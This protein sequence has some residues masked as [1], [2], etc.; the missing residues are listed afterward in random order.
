MDTIDWIAV[1]HWTCLGITIQCFEHCFDLLYFCT[2]ITVKS[3]DLFWATPKLSFSF[4][5]AIH[6]WTCLCVFE[7]C[8]PASPNYTSASA[9]RQMTTPAL[10]QKIFRRI[11]HSFFNYGK[12]SRSCGSNAS[13]HYT[14]LPPYLIF[15]WCS[16]HQMLFLLYTKHDR[17]CVIQKV[18]HLS[19]EYYPRRHGD[20]PTNIDASV[21]W[22]WFL[23]C[24]SPMNPVFAQFLIVESW[25]LTTVETRESCTSLNCQETARVWC[26]VV[27]VIRQVQAMGHTQ[28]SKKGKSKQRSKPGNPEYKTLLLKN[29]QKCSQ[30]G[31]KM[32]NVKNRKQLKTDLQ[33]QGTQ[34]NR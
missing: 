18:T 6:M 21:S 15:V 4:F 24:Y 12:S 34:N 14:V 25:T 32:K 1:I 9:H 10:Y 17:T 27:D 28:Q 31:K 30:Q 8:L 2:F 16:S 23:F 5:S 20:H 29:K 33:I 19:I 3:Q 11:T 7:H 13:P 26:E 22:Q